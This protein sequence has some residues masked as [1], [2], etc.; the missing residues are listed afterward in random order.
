MILKEVDNSNIKALEELLESAPKNKKRPIELEIYRL[1]RGFSGE[2]NAGYY[3]EQASGEKSFIAHDIRLDV[4]GDIAQIDH[5]RINRFSSVTLFETKHFS[6]DIKIDEK[7]CFFYKKEGIYRPFP[8]PIKQSERHEKVLKKAFKLVGFTP[9]FINH[10]ILFSY[11]SKIEKPKGFGNVCYPD[12]I[13]EAV[14]SNV[15]KS[16]PLSGLGSVAKKLIKPS[17]SPKEAL[18]EIINAFHKPIK[19]DYEAKFGLPRKEL[20]NYEKLTLPKFSKLNA[21]S[22]VQVEE[23]LLSSNFI[24][25]VK[26]VLYATDKGEVLGIESKKGRYGHYILIP[27][28]FNL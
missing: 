20:T 28:N 26:G 9:I 22:K 16:N 13:H 23:S 11:D 21:M 12:F 7:G 19:F 27:K 15:D 24:I 2:K 25:K 17:L 1:K 5:I 6:N 10:V 14:D 18:E 4:G 3:I 8:S